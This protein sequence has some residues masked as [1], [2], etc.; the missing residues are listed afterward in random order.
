MGSTPGGV[1][2]LSTGQCASESVAGSLV[3]ANVFSVLEIKI[4]HLFCINT[5]LHSINIP[6]VA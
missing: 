2:M 4:L 1:V 3:L 5:K 6:Y